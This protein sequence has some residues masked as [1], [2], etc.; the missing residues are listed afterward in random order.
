MIDDGC[1]CCHRALALSDTQASLLQIFV[2][3]AERSIELKTFSS[4]SRLQ[5]VLS[6]L[7][8]RTVMLPRRIL[9]GTVSWQDQDDQDEFGARNNVSAGSGTLFAVFLL[10][11]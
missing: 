9:A 6:D 10:L 2:D 11:S 4:D 5:Y 1:C 3:D 7:H 8:Y